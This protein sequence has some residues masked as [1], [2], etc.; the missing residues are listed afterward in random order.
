MPCLYNLQ[1]EQGGKPLRVRCATFDDENN[2][3]LSRK[4]CWV[5]VIAGFGQSDLSV[6]IRK[7]E[8]PLLLGLSHVFTS[9][10]YAFNEFYPGAWFQENAMHFVN[11][12]VAHRWH[13]R[14]SAVFGWN[15]G[16]SD[17]STATSGWT[18]DHPQIYDEAVYHAPQSPCLPYL[19]FV[20]IYKIPHYTDTLCQEYKFNLW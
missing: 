7:R 15:L 20:L 11:G 12:G 17:Y 14:S 9:D 10:L 18:A 4:C 19:L 16:G 1:Q 5:R 3:K 2:K 6:G 13:C 8:L